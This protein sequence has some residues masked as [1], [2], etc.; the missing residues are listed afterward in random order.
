MFQLRGPTLEKRQAHFLSPIGYV[1][2]SHSKLGY[3][4]LLLAPDLP[5]S[6]CVQS[7]VSRCK[8]REHTIDHMIHCSWIVL[9][10]HGKHHMPDSSIGRKLVFRYTFCSHTVVYN[11]AWY[12]AKFPVRSRSLMERRLHP[13]P[14]KR[15]DWLSISPESC[16]LMP[17]VSLMAWPYLS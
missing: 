14:P 5:F 8:E 11:M 4:F 6:Y 3:L 16:T 1:L 15:L 10:I 17:K 7:N 2:E 12:W 9:Q 13:G